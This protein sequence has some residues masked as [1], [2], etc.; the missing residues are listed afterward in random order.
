MNEL[1]RIE[2]LETRLAYQEEL[3]Q[4]LNDVV[5]RQQKQIEQLEAS[6]RQLAERLRAPEGGVFRGT[7]ADEVPPHY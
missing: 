4:V 7:P 1:Q 5:T 2:E 3:L 6:C